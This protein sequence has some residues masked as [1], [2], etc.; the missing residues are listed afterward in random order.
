[1]RLDG[2]GVVVTGGASGLGLATAKAFVA[3]G[4]KVAIFDGMPRPARRRRRRS[5]ASSAM[6]M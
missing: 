5:A 2:I 3:E 4:A 1:M 6:S